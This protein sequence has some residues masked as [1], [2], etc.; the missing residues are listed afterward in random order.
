MGYA[1]CKAAC[2]LPEDFLLREGRVV[3][4]SGYQDV[5]FFC[6]A[7]VRALSRRV[8]CSC[9]ISAFLGTCR[10]KV[11]ESV[12]KD[13]PNTARLGGPPPWKGLNA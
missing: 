13:R 3:Q 8:A 1:E 10:P 4:G 12:E 2:A 7:D 5:S 6:D 11:Q 9:R